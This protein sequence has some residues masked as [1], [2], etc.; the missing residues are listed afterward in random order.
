M[1]AAIAEINVS[2]SGDSAGRNASALCGREL[3]TL[4]VGFQKARNQF[5]SAE[6]YTEEAQG[7]LARHA[8]VEATTTL[9][10]TLQSYTDSGEYSEYCDWER[11]YRRDPSSERRDA[12]PSTL[13]DR[14]IR[15]A[16][17]DC[18]IEVGGCNA[19]PGAVQDEL[20]ARLKEVAAEGGRAVV[21]LLAEC[22]VAE[23]ALKAKAR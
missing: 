19:I 4:W 8:A 9:R 23:R 15:E 17:D 22:A 16:I 2:A 5:A 13:I 18:A 6:H 7:E 14:A 11:A 1:A 20:K 12:E 21:A 3:T 10:L